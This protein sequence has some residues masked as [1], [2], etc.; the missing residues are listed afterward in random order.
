VTCQIMFLREMLAQHPPAEAGLIPRDFLP[1]RPWSRLR[2]PFDYVHYVHLH[3]SPKG[4]LPKIRLILKE[5]K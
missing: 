3:S 2:L 1:L 4:L 5:C